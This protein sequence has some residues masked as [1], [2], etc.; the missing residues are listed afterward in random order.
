MSSPSIQFPVRGSFHKTVRT[1]VRDYI[2]GQGQTERDLPQMYLKTAFIVSLS[3]VSY[4]MLV[5][6]SSSLQAALLWGFLLAQGHIMIGFCVMHDGGHGGYS[7]NPR[8]NN[9]MGYMLDMIGGSQWLW[10]HK[11]NVLHHTYTNIDDLDDDIHAAP[12]LRLS[13]VQDRK[14][15]HRYQ[16]WYALP[17]YSLLSLY[18]VFYSDFSEYFGGKIGDY[19]FPK[20][21]TRDKVVFWGGKAFYF[22]YA[23]VVPM[24]LHH[25]LHVL[26]GFVGVH[27]ILGFTLSLVFQLAH[28][29]ELAEFPEPGPD[30]TVGDEW[31]VHQM[32]TTANFAR[33]NPL[34]NFYVGGL[35]FQVE[36]HLFS[37]ICHIHY[38][39]ISR[40]VKET[41]EEFGVPYNEYPSVMA[42][43]K[44]H[45]SFLNQM[46]QPQGNPA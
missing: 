21:K 11:H 7:S 29:V 10:N 35:N 32:K 36:H 9:V 43:I 26:A 4:V 45:L 14:P 34:V 38:P 16:A 30:G 20:P 39:A 25:P 37:K 2:A 23:L 5:F 28:T 27:M 12:M 41:A 18:W 13:P 8:V 15:W 1:R 6:F 31:A 24:L 46:G 33:R 17:L 19:E 22:T 3:V 42:A 40:I 44:S